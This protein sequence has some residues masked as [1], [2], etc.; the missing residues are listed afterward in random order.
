MQSRHDKDDKDDKSDDEP[1][2]TANESSGDEWEPE[3]IVKERWLVDGHSSQ[4]QYVIRWKGHELKPNMWTRADHNDEFDLVNEPSIKQSW[5]AKT[6]REAVPWELK[7]TKRKISP[8]T[9]SQTLK[10]AKQLGMQEKW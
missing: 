7:R 8:S 1:M 6:S 2:S 9:A 3:E 5:R 10:K 4:R